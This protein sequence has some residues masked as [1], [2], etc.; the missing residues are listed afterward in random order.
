M[1]I[2]LRIF[3]FEKP[4]LLPFFAP[5]SYSTPFHTLIKAKDTLLTTTL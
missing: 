2:G 5:P 1:E 4:N 3:N